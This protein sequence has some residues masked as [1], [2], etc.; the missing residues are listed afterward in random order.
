MPKITKLFAREILDSRGN[1]TVEAEITL[2]ND[3]HG[4][5]SVPS[6][7]STGSY[8]AWELRDGDLKRFN[9]QG[10]QKAV[11]NINATIVPSLINLA[12]R[13]DTLDRQLIKLDGTVNKKNLGANTILGVS[14]AFAHAMA[15]Y[16]RQPL[17]QY[18]ARIAK[19]GRLPRLPVPLMNI[20]NG[21]KHAANSTDFQEFMIVPIGATTFKEALRYGVE[22]FHALKAILQK[23]KLNTTVGDEGG[24]APKLKSNQ[25]AI[26]LILQAITKANYK[27]GQ[28]IALAIDAAATELYKNGRYHLSCEKKVFT[29]RQMID[30]YESWIKKYPIISIEDGLAEDD[31]EGFE[32]LTTRLGKKI[33]IVGDDLFVTNVKRLQKGIMDIKA[34]NSI[35][36]KLNQIG[37]VTETIEAIKLALRHHYTAIISHRSGETEDTT[38]ADLVVGLGTGQIKTGSLCRSERVC[39]Y[40]QLLRIEELLDRKAL[41]PG[42]SAFK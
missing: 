30:F 28:D 7:A 16:H 40:N 12:W 27:P 21:G 19:L 1:P 24:F 38:I 42:I 39:K 3:Y 41:Y 13:Q 8:E 18:F 37:T 4:R 22:T 26:E 32:V 15:N 17:F 31:W 25:E 10:V 5:A 11:E 36:I 35:L 29:S 9:G 33:Q 6:G 2:N 23:K 20:L 34:A 14:L